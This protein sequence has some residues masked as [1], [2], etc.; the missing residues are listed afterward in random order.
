MSEVI[1]VLSGKGGVGKTT[2]VSN[3]G[4]AL[5]NEFGKNVVVID[6]N[7]NSSH[8]G[9][10]MGLYQDLPVTLRE[11]IRKGLPIS[12]AVYVHPSTGIRIVPAALNSDGVLPTPQKLREITDRLKKDYEMIVMDCPPGLGSE[13]VTAITAID[14]AVVVTTPDF[15]SVADALKTVQLLEK[16]RKGILG[17][18][19]NKK[20]GKGYELTA[21]EVEST[22]GVSVIGTVPEDKHVPEA[23]SEGVPVVLLYPNSPASVELKK[24]AA[25]LIGMQ[26]RPANIVERIIGNF[27]KSRSYGPGVHTPVPANPPTQPVVSPIMQPQK[28]AGTHTIQQRGVAD[29]VRRDDLTEE[30][31]EEIRQEL[32]RQIMQ[33][34]KER[35]SQ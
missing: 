5:T 6:A 8:L 10:H 12:Y 34:V 15:P 32:K 9:L 1:G 7:L 14:S 13:V 30:M 33:K 2:L 4:A 16:M 26:Y 20:K 22:C 3:I 18:V 29:F 27:V 23:I 11:V 35:L 31:K 28:A 17:I 21:K 19:I 25:S 24:V